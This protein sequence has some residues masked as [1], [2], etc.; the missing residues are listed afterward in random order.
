MTD[1]A[2]VTSAARTQGWRHRTARVITEVFAPWVVV[3]LL[4]LS[5]AWKATEYRILPTLGWG[6]LA[7]ATSS[8]IPQAVIVWGARRGRWDGHHVRDRAGRLIPFIAL[9]GSGAIG[10]TALW[11][12]G[13]PWPLVALDITM[14]AL[15]IIAGVITVRWKVSMHAAA[16]GGAAVVLAVFYGPLW[17]AATIVVAAIAWSRVQLR[18]HTPAQVAVGALLGALVI[19]G[20]FVAL[21]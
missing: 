1:S 21:A 6:L 9:I 4:P 3:M 17:W 15:V 7:A 14:L 2:T 10:L 18:D 13:A 11:L 12:G 5:V 8:L 19:G 16:A 20:G